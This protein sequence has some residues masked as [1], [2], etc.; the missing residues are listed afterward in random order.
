MTVHEPPLE[1]LLYSKVEDFGKN[2]GPA[3]AG[4]ITTDIEQANVI[5]SMIADRVTHHKVVIDL[6]LPTKL[7]PSSTP[8]HFHLYIDHEMELEPYMKLLKA[9]LEAGLVEEGYVNAAI[10]RG[11]TAVRLPWIK[12]EAVSEITGLTVKQM[13][14]IDAMSLASMIQKW[15]HAR[16]GEFKNGEPYTEYFFSVMKAK[17]DADPAEWSRASKAIRS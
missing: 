8:G 4:T 11:H 7:V 10:A 9:L 5:T 1:G 15:T 16:L 14:G 13:E 3:G 17:R 2:Y 6:D 12:K